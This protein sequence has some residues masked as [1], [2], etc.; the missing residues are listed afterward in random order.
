MIFQIRPIG[1]HHDRM[2]L[3]IPKFKNPEDVKETRELPLSER[4]GRWRERKTERRKSRW[5]LE[6]AIDADLLTSFADFLVMNLLSFSLL[7]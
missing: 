6:I 5:S 3:E 2:C 4:T 1:Q 7:F